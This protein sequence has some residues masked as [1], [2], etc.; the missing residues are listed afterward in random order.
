MKCGKTLFPNPFSDLL[1]S[2]SV[3]TLGFCVCSALIRKK[4]E[5]CLVWNLSDFVSYLIPIVLSSRLVSN[6]FLI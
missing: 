1:L 3:E 4:V 6:F 5:F 2:F